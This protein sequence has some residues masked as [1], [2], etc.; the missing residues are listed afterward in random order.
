[1]SRRMAV[2]HNVHALLHGRSHSSFQH[3]CHQ[4]A[5]QFDARYSTVSL[6][7]RKHNLVTILAMVTKVRMNHPLTLSL[8]QKTQTKYS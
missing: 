1:V 7:Q 2:S 5:L 6:S 8:P 3:S 4:L